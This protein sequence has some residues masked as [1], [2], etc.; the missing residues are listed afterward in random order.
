MHDND[1]TAA[2]RHG[3]YVHV[4]HNVTFVL[5]GCYAAFDSSFELG[6][7]QEKNSVCYYQSQT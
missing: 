1:I 7:L 5:H 4:L 3:L 2:N 6:M